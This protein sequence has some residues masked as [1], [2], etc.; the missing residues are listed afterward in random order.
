[1]AFLVTG[2]L[3]CNP[4]NVSEHKNVRNNLRNIL[5]WMTEK[6]HQ[7]N[8]DCKVCD[9]HHE[10]I[11]RLRSDASNKEIDDNDSNETESFAKITVMQSLNE[12]LQSR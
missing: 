9:R 8:S 6:C 5:S 2:A 7:L 12:S 11:S 1:M 4:F 3:C 10:K